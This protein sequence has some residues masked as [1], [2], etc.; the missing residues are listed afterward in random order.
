MQFCNAK[1]NQPMKTGGK[2]Q[3]KRKAGSELYQA[4]WE[5]V[6]AGTEALCFL[7]APT[8]SHH[9]RSDWYSQITHSLEPQTPE[10][11]QPKPSQTYS[12]IQNL[13]WDLSLSVIVAE[14]KRRNAKLF[15]MALLRHLDPIASWTIHPNTRTDISHPWDMVVQM[16]DPQ[17]HCNL[18]STRGTLIGINPNL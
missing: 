1:K 11:L 16:Q 3:R 17:S 15:W 7:L 14:T 12:K 5:L 9:M 18:P 2:C 8:N 10:T 13:N 6:V 4:T